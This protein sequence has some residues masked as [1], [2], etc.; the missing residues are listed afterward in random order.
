MSNQNLVHA[1]PWNSLPFFVF[2]I[3]SL[4]GSL[5]H[6][7][8]EPEIFTFP[9]KNPLL[10]GF[11]HLLVLGWI[12]SFIAGSAYQ[13]IPVLTG[14]NLWFPHGA[15]IHAL[16]HITGVPVMIGGFHSGNSILLISGGGIVALGI[17]LLIINGIATANVQSLWTIEAVTVVQVLS[18]LTVTILLGIWMTFER[19]GVS[20]PIAQSAMVSIHLVSGIGGGFLL[21]LMGVS[22]KLL[23]MFLISRL[24]FPAPAWISNFLW[25]IG[26]FL[27]IISFFPTAAPLQGWGLAALFV[28][29]I[30]YLVS[31]AFIILDKNRSLDAP[32]GLFLFGIFMMLPLLYLIIE[33]MAQW[34]GWLPHSGEFGPR[35][36]I[37]ANAFSI[38]SFTILGMAMKIIPFLVWQLRFASKLGKQSVPPI[39]QMTNPALNKIANVIVILSAIS[40]IGAFLMVH[41]LLI[42]ISIT[43]VLLGVL[44]ISI[45]L[46]YSIR[47]PNVSK[48]LSHG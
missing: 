2:G 37:L 41:P 25:N 22:F 34:P 3:I 31:V 9:A 40:L 19:F 14:A 27:L 16:L 45:N 47:S 30:L 20:M 36:L 24:R 38:L 7:L 48:D 35:I 46:I 23:P 33:L 15:K 6:F 42:R 13:L 29:L 18:W 12:M 39:A 8:L 4:F 1:K 21:L 26:V 10:L 17:L 32:I 43:G 11:V 44:L 28:G 5:A